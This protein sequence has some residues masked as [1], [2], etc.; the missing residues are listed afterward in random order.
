MN[1]SE[2]FE[3]IQGEGA[4]MGKPMLFIRLS[5]CNLSCTWCDTPYAQEK[6][7]DMTAEEV[8]GTIRKS[9]LSHV[10]WTGGEPLLQKSSIEKVVQNT[11]DKTHCLETNGTIEIPDDVFDVITVSPKDLSKAPIIGADVY[12]F[13]VGDPLPE[14]ISEVVSYVQEHNIP[15]EKVYLQP[16]CS[17]SKEARY[18]SAIIWKA[19]VKHSFALSPRLHTM[20]FDNRRGV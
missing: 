1:V 15:A 4:L 2:I 16:L 18:M 17:T 7:S 20:I 3:S 14:S 5:G 6:G 11:K 9:K 10:C 13:V 12:K 8:A 19:C